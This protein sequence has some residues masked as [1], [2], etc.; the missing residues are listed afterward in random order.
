MTITIKPYWKLPLETQRLIK[1]I[2]AAEMTLIE[3][4]KRIAIMRANNKKILDNIK[5][6]K[7]RKA[8]T[9]KFITADSILRGGRR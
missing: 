7:R 8:R 1:R 2:A 6:I 5:R 4:A 9:R 3:A